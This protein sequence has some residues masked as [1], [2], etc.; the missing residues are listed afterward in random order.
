MKHLLVF[1]NYMRPNGFI[2]QNKFLADGEQYHIS[3][4]KR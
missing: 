1:L 4:L 2:E 3:K